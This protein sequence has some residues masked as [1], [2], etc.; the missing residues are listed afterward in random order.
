[1]Q[2]VAHLRYGVLPACVRRA[3]GSGGI[4]VEFGDEFVEMLAGSEGVCYTLHGKTFPHWGLRRR[5]V[6]QAG[7][8]AS[9]AFFLLAHYYLIV[10]NNVQAFFTENMLLKGYFSKSCK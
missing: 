10:D 9:Q 7:K 6:T 3:E 8:P 5:L 2:V 1:V 4:A